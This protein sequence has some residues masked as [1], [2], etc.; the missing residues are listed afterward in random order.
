MAT[1]ADVKLADALQLEIDYYSQP[2]AD[3]ASIAEEQDWIGTAVVAIRF[4]RSAG[5]TDEQR[6]TARKVLKD[7]PPQ[8]P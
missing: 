2:G 7:T 8:R 6:E 4:L 3:E 5:T 1:D